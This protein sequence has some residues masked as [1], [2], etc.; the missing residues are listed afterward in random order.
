MEENKLIPTHLDCLASYQTIRNKLSFSVDEWTGFS[1]DGVLKEYPEEMKSISL[2]DYPFVSFAFLKGNM[3]KRVYPIF[4]F[5]LRKKEKVISIDSDHPILSP[6]VKEILEDNGINPERN[7]GSFDAVGWITSLSE[8]LERKKL[9]GIFSIVY[10]ISYFGK[11]LT[12]LV[13]AYPFLSEYKQSHI[14][15]EKYKG[16]FHDLNDEEF[17]KEIGK[18]NFGCFHRIDHALKRLDHYRSSKVSYQ[19]KEIISDALFRFLDHFI[20][21]GES[22]LVLTP[23]SEYQVVRELFD[24]SVIS[25]KEKGLAP[26][27]SKVV[28]SFRQAEERYLSFYE[29][30]EECFSVLE[31]Y[32][33]Q[34]NIEYLAKIRKC[35]V[36]PLS[37][38][39][40]TEEQYKKD[41]AFLASFSSYP[42][43]LSYSLGKH[44]YYGL[45]LS[46]KRENYDMLQ[47]LY[48]RIATSVSKLRTELNKNPIFLNYSVNVNSLSDF[49]RVRKSFQI[50]SEYNGF[51]KKYF[52]L[53]QKGDKTLSLTQLKLR[54]QALSS[55]RLLAL[56]FLKEEIFSIDIQ[57]LLIRYESGSFFEKRKAKRILS[58]Y[59]IH[60][61]GT[62]LTTVIRILD[63]Y[64]TSKKELEAVLPTYEEI[65]GDNIK[66]MNGVMEI[67]SNIRYI[68]KFNEY[69]I[70]NHAFSLEH[71]FIRRYLKDKDFR[72]E[73]QR[74]FRELLNIYNE[75]CAALNQ[76]LS[77]FA[78][79][80]RREHH[81]TF[82]ELMEEIRRLQNLDYENFREYADFVHNL[83]DCSSLLKDSLERYGK[84]DGN[85]AEFPGCYRLSLFYALYQKCHK[86]FLPYES[87]YEKARG[88]YL[89]A[90]K[91]SKEVRILN[92]KEKLSE[93]GKENLIQL[94]SVSEME[95]HESESF[96]H[97]ILLDTGLFTN[98]QLLFGFSLGKD[99][100]L[101]NDRLLFDER[102]QG[103][104]QTLMNREVLYQK[105]FDFS[106]LGEETKA[107]LMEHYRLYEDDRYPFLYHSE[108]WEKAVLPDC[109]LTGTYDVHFVMELA[110]F[111]SEEENALLE[112]VDLYPLLCEKKH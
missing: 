105:V 104:H 97:V 14:I 60:K 79:A 71:P 1:S 75:A 38:R 47:L 77:Y 110:R 80:N 34:E 39:E 44:P 65:Y 84:E 64:L 58:S 109:L 54:Y 26:E 28:L 92:R 35:S 73:S 16:L 43:V 13:S 112:I 33:N 24:K 37:I 82:D 101:L 49:E 45:S 96:D 90:L 53:N 68:K 11:D 66:T 5:F 106:S 18:D 55:S 100:L 83:S 17:E 40:Y 42:E 86:A 74:Q 29:K 85:L 76:L 48:V 27:E 32:D 12:A 51:P 67:E 95:Y 98:E 25:S 50:L 3:E 62:D 69:S 23:D 2:K 22:V 99:I 107:M 94:F 72:L 30:K 7:G 108:D 10:G 9:V 70:E 81:F 56:N 111:F 36:F 31:K 52:R 46:S 78:F 87:G 88:E 21:N 102:T 93:S 6:V 4:F 61:K 57:G 89:L 91:K 15:P 8:E 63:S 20:E 103:Y 19:G 41:D 59:L